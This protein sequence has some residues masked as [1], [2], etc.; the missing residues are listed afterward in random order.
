MAETPLP[1]ID[2]EVDLAN[3]KKLYE[4]KTCVLCHGADGKANTPM[5]KA[6]S[7]TDLTV[8]AFKNNTKKLPRMDYIFQV[9][10]NGVPGTAMVSFKDQI[11]SDTDKLDLASYV[12]SLKE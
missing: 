9:I 12:N 11:K 8:G 4:V 1:N 7:A 5:G 6:V 2:R 10:E 3:G